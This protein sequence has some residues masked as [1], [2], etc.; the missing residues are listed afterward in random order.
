LPS[1]AIFVI[2]GRSNKESEA[3]SLSGQKEGDY[4]RFGLYQNQQSDSAVA[5]THRVLFRE[6]EW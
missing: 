5:R 4:L 1:A 2:D 6:K 3:Q